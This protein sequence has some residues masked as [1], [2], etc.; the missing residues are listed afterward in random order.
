MYD[1]KKQSRRYAEE[2][3]LAK[4]RLNHVKR[5]DRIRAGESDWDEVLTATA[6]ALIGFIV[7]AVTMYYSVLPPV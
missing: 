1:L 6:F 4:M 5:M 3:K 7:G 2:R